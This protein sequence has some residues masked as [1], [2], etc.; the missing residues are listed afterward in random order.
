MV[1]PQTNTILEIELI[2]NAVLLFSGALNDYKKKYNAK[3]QLLNIPQNIP[4]DAPR[5]I[6][7]IKNVVINISLTRLEIICKVPDHIESNSDAVIEFT[8]KIVFDIL[9]HF[10]NVDLKYSWLGL[11]STIDYALDRDEKTALQLAKPFFD[12]LVNIDRKNRDLGSFQ[13]KFGF[14]ENNFFKNYMITCFEKRDIKI[15]PS[16]FPTWQKIYDLE[17]FSE[18]KK[19]GLRVVLDINNKPNDHKK[20][21]FFDLDELIKY[22][23]TDIVTIPN[24]LNIVDLI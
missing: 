23:K 19:S 14:K 12:Y 10:W 6:V 18:I 16:K 7:S 9:S 13:I 2:D 1:I 5:I 17:E 21:Y 3:I 4:P 20:D 8:R 24:E 22:I 11:V 15:D